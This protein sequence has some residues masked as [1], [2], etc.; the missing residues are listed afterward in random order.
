MNENVLA[1]S[2]GAFTDESVCVFIILFV[3]NLQEIPQNF[4]LFLKTRPC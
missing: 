3:L 1:G 2:D 4:I